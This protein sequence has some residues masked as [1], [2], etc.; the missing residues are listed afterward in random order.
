MSHTTR[1]VKVLL[2]VLLSLAL[3]P[4]SALAGPIED[5]A[6]GQWYQIPNSKMIA[7]D[8]CPAR[9]CLYSGVEGGG[10]VIWSWSGGAYDTKRNRLLV[11]GGGHTAYAGNEVYAFDLNTFLWTRVTEPSDITGHVNGAT[12]PSDGRPAS[13][14]S[15]DQI[16]Y[17]PV[18]DR[19]FAFGGSRWQSGSNTSTAFTFNFDTKNWTQ[20]ADIIGDSYSENIGLSLNSAYDPVTGLVYIG[21]AWTIA[22]YN[23]NTNVWKT[24]N[25]NYGG[26]GLPNGLTAAL[27]YNKRQFVQIGR[28]Y[29]YMWDISVAAPVRTN[30]VT[31]GDKEIELCD[32][33]GLDYDPVS[34]KIVGWCKGT[35]VYT[36]DVTTKVWTKIA[37]GS[38]VTPG[39]PYAS[40]G[41]HGTFGRFRY[42][43]S[44]N[45]FVVVTDQN[46]DVF[47]YKLP[48][49]TGGGGTAPTVTLTA[50]PTSVTSGSS[51]TLSW[52][53][54]NATSCTASGAWSGVKGTS[55]SQTTGPLTAT[56]TYTLTCGSAVQGVTVSISS[57][58]TP[59]PTLTFSA[60]PTSVTSGSPT[61]LTWSATN[62]NSCTA[63]GAW[64]GTLGT[65]SSASLTPAITSTYTLTCT[66][67]GG[68]VTQS[69]VV[70]VTAPAP[71]PS[72]AITT[73]QLQNTTATAQTNA[74]IT[75]GHVFKQG[76][77]PAGSTV[78][79]K[80]ASNNP[81]T[82]QV[83]KKATHA[84]GSLRHAILTAKL[85][86]LAGSATQTITLYAQADGTAQTPVS[87]T[88]LLATTFDS[89]V[90]LNVGGT[91]YTASARNLLQTTT[92]K[93]WLSGPEVSEWIVG[94]PVKTAAGVAHPHLTAYFH[95]RAY[96][97]SPI[98]KVRVDA[99]VEN[100]WTMVAA[101]SDFTYDVNLTVGGTSVYTQT[102]L[103]HFTR[104]RWHKVF[105]WGTEPTIYAKHDK[106]Y[107][108]DTKAVSK[109]ANVT[110]PESVLS[111]MLKSIA[112]MQ[113]GNN[114]SYMATTGE[115]GMI[116]PQPEWVSVYLTSM[117]KRALT[118]SLYNADGGSTYNSHYR[119][120]T[121][122]YPSTTD[123]YPI[124]QIG[125]PIYSGWIP[126]VISTSPHEWDIAH[127]PALAYVPYLVTGDYYYLEEMQFWAEANMLQT[128]SGTRQSQ[129]GLQ[130]RA[131]AW[132]LR[133][134]AEAA[135]AT[136]DTHPLKKHLN[137]KVK[138]YVSKY[139]TRYT[140]D[141]TAN[142][143]G[144]I[145]SS[146]D[147]ESSLKLSNAYFT[148]W[149]DDYLT[150]A[151]GHLVELGFTE[152]IPFRNWKTK[153]VTDRMGGSEAA[154]QMCW[155]VASPSQFKMGEG[156]V[157]YPDIQTVYANNYPQA[158]RDLTCNTQAYADYVKIN[159]GEPT[160]KINAM[161]PYGNSA[162]GHPMKAQIAL[163]TAVD[164]GTPN[165]DLGWTRMSTRVDAPDLSLNPKYA[166]I[167]RGAPSGGGTP[168][169]T[170]SISA[171]PTTVTSG[172]S[173]TITWSST[174]TTT[175][176][177][178]GAWGG[179]VG[180]SG[181]V[182]LSPTTTSTYTIT[183]TGAG[184]TATQS[185]T[186][187]VGSTPPP[188][189][190][191]LPAPWTLTDIGAPTPA[192]TASFS[193]GVYT[194]TVGGVDIWNTADQFSFINQPITGDAGII[195]RVDSLANTYPWAKSGI[196]IRDAL[197]PGSAN[198]AIFVTPTNGITFQRRT[199]QDGIST[200]VNLTTAGTAPRYLRLVRTGTSISAYYGDGPTG[201][202]TLVGS[203]TISMTGT[204]YIGLA[205][206]SHVQ[207]TGM[208]TVFS[209]VTATSASIPSTKFSL[210][211]R[212]QVTASAINVRA[213]GSTSGTL[214][215]TQANNAL[216]TIIG[217]PVAADGFNWWNINYDTGV[218]GWSAENYVTKYSSAPVDTIAPTAP[219]ALTA[220]P[221]SSSQINLSWTAS[222]DA[223]SVTG[224]KVY[225]NG[226]QVGTTA[227][228]TYSDTALAAATSY[229]YAVSAYDA[230]GNNS[231]QSS[232]VNGTTNPASGS[233]IQVGPT[234]TYKTPSQAVAAATT[235]SVVEIDA[236]IY[237]DDISVWRQ[238]NLTL[239]GVGGRAHIR[240]TKLIPYTP[241]NDQENGMGIVVIKGS[242]VTIEN[243]EFS[244][245]LVDDKNG[246]GVR[247]EG[248]GATIR[249]SYF[250]NNE[251]GILGGVGN[252][253]IENSEFAYNGEC[254]A[255][256]GCSH[257][258]YI[259]SGTT[260]LTFRGN[261]SHHAI[262]GHTL[263]SRAAENYIIGNRITDETGTAS[264]EID[265]PN[266]GRS[267]VMGNLIQQS[268]NTD[269]ATIISYGAEGLLN[270]LKDL[271]VVNNTVVN[272][273][274]S[275]TFVS[276]ATGG[277][278]QIQNNLFIGG[279]TILSGPGT[280]TNNLTPSATN[281]VS[282]ST[283]NYH[284]TG[285]AA[286]I[287]AGTSAGSTASGY[288]LTPTLEYVHPLNTQVR[289][290]SGALDVGAY[291]YTGAVVTP[292]P[293]LTLSASPTTVSS[294]SSST[295]TWSST[296]ATSCSL[297][298][299]P[300]VTGISGTA[301][302]SNITSTGTYSMMCTGSGGSV[303]Q[304]VTITVT[305]PVTPPTVTLSSPQTT[306]TSGNTATLMWSSTNAT[307]CTASGAWGG[308][309]ALSGT[310]TL[311]PTVTGT[312]TLTCTNTAGSASQSIT[313]TVTTATPV[314]T[315]TISA[316][317]AS[318]TSGSPITLTWSSTNA[319]TCT[320]SNGWTGTKAISGTQASNPTTTTT[321]TL[322][323]TGAGGSSAQSTTVTVTALPLPTVSLTSPQTTITSGS[324]ASLAWS[325]TNATTCT[326]S[327]A[328]SGAKA[329]SGTQTLTALT[330]TGTYTL[331]CTN[332]T[333]S[334]NRS[335]TITVTA[336]V[337]LPTVS[338]TS[339]QTT[340]TSGSNASLAWSSTNASTC[341]AS[342]AWS[343]SKTLSGT[344]TLTALT[345]TGTYTLTCTNTTGSVN[346]SVIIT[347][348]AVVPSAPTATITAT[349]T[350]VT[351]GGST[352][353]AWSSTNAT[354][355]TATGGTNGWSGTKGISGTQTFSNLSANT[356]YTM[357]C[358]GSGGTTAPQSTTVV[359]T[360]PATPTVTLTANTTSVTSGGTAILTW[361]STNASTCTA[362]GAW[363]GNKTLSGTQTL[364]NLTT[365][366]TYTMTCGTATQSL[367]IA[368]AAPSATPN[369]TATITAN[370]TSITSGGSTVL[371]WSSAN[372]S[373]CSASGGWSG[374]K[375]LSG[376]ETISSIGSAAS[377]TLTCGTATQSTN[378]SVAAPAPALSGAGGGSSG[379][380]SS[381]GGG[382]SIAPAPVVVTPPS[383]QSNVVTVTSS[384]AAT[385]Q[386]VIV[387][388]PTQGGGASIPGCAGTNRFSTT[389]GQLCPAPTV[390]F[391]PVF[392]TELKV[393]DKGPLVTTLQN[394]L[395]SEKL[396]TATPT[397]YFGPATKTALV[398]FQAKYRSEIGGGGQAVSDGTFA[399]TT[400]AKA[401]SILAQRSITT[402]TVT[403]GASTP[404]PTGTTFKRMLFVGSRGADVMALQQVLAQ[405]GFFTATPTQY[406]GPLTLKALKLFQ[407]KYQISGPNLPGYGNLGPKTRGKL[408][409]M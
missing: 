208:T 357:T 60:N 171:N 322:T 188:T 316:T 403:P 6:P 10:S 360:A 315:V 92:P 296:N 243:M 169:P 144:V 50:T 269:N 64:G 152:A 347:V 369:P 90:S 222:T 376:T 314:P 72:G 86:S 114:R 278:A 160:F 319:T 236:G 89:Q 286:G 221:A 140:D 287:N 217:G 389:T 175:C 18:A 71:A 156:L 70:T 74:P 95:V 351:S 293:T 120:E 228:P 303:T 324:N 66:G 93:Q 43:P 38:S 289:T 180:L 340:I 103:T 106:V 39:D 213:T 216:G 242:N 387:P 383:I 313:I 189:G 325:S 334:V 101:P 161:M 55:G 255:G 24:L 366:G 239:R 249:N 379:G 200:S 142:K 84:D 234:R 12:Y 297:S 146:N 69:V 331:T 112:P 21:G 167:P 166:I 97:G 237:T 100:N 398:K 159:N 321:Y 348:T 380:G 7:V 62:A 355:C 165:A 394:L 105:W 385:G 58:P 364:S 88:N 42:V 246:A 335:V 52:T 276:V 227:T 201:P 53:S 220:T 326:A 155:Q 130:V 151:V 87:L 116:G 353:I 117:D 80:D 260:K 298:G 361:T 210:N 124:M 174:N 388:T 257:N 170:L 125:E 40:G 214:L 400:R 406:F 350:S 395:V 157:W 333:G 137:D 264:Y 272:S 138:L 118:A 96:S 45:V 382:G 110:P 81:V 211:D 57:T 59:A 63:G 111:G 102:A 68:T 184:G 365:T 291:E 30:L 375:G 250:H 28:G 194:V 311:T 128:S 3:W 197:T 231:A 327:G 341:T 23:V 288:A 359:V 83:D 294:G 307:S 134:L 133:T 75:F 51:A 25:R 19:M 108:Q 224:Y 26:W 127:Q 304:S 268:V 34:G 279:G 245:A 277:T 195:A 206:T 198:V 252:V 191:S 309:A 36:L 123:D 65:V 343:G 132:G 82:L 282:E 312:Y 317:P 386:P 273:R 363:S 342:G 56:A 173:S 17:D 54:T 225:R 207:G 323:C 401:N 190:G 115:N 384:V 283:Y 176:T 378:V 11:W 330:A 33:P 259:G 181:S 48:T 131:Q 256:F 16:E 44:K 233:V 223:V 407:E 318:V 358:T 154:G 4:S 67:S 302:I 37:A 247:L 337:P 402:T 251:N 187:T 253:L 301:T 122:G 345:A 14:H 27:D 2:A 41:Y 368:V 267:V 308:N 229:M 1:F 163:A 405:E 49:T 203:I 148:V 20:V 285:T 22:T 292:A 254:I 404:A 94:G 61:T 391:T 392:T 240:S 373:T 73:V 136:P 212:V 299:V 109:Y 295:L 77:V 15:Y 9:N 172:G 262:V 218:D 280:L 381:G 408:N 113:I 232:A 226:T 266:G 129:I 147:A 377:F 196:M 149:M 367:T 215:G 349:P 356:T 339:P 78:I 47:V 374:T 230:A 145:W 284:L 5:L 143:L 261:Y 306:I 164:A 153:F 183:C 344:Q 371:T 263:K 107:L 185:V 397:G 121:T 79:A 409:T 178:S 204:D 8:P 202:W 338:L 13:V 150:W 310:Q 248:N 85:P 162:D 76:D 274:G 199:A 396:L 177:A 91:V 29:A 192:G 35:D 193:S 271:Y 346:Q 352:V 270:P 328:W 305:V 336:A 275:G 46:R 168:A 235:G 139:T 209:N 32:A 320:A 390:T 354:S 399:T 182:P 126:P 258:L 119:N 205:A 219:T 31:T 300:S 179:T 186:V 98:T 104:A 244:G 241:G 238:N 362:S 332:T 141:P 135:Y 290:I 99:V 265:L 158:L 329:T 370:P 281:L 393:G 372:A